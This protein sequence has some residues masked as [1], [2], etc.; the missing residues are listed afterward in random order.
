MNKRRSDNERHNANQT[1]MNTRMRKA[2]NIIKSELV[3][4]KVMRHMKDTA[5]FDKFV[6]A[7]ELD[8]VEFRVEMREIHTIKEE[9]GFVMDNLIDIDARSNVDIDMLLDKLHSK[10]DE[11]WKIAEG[12][13]LRI[14]AKEG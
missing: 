12:D 13:E 8:R 5:G 1:A 10:L 3:A 14:E 11:A 4:A 7:L 6:E 9:I 2:Y